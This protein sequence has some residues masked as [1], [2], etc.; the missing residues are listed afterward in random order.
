[1]TITQTDTTRAG[2]TVVTPEDL[3]RE[4][5]AVPLY[6]GITAYPVAWT[7]PVNGERL[8]REAF[9]R[10]EPGAGYPEQDVH[11]DSSETVL[12]LLG[13]LEDENGSYTPG[14]RI[15]GARGSFHTPRS[16]TGCL[17]YV[18]FPDR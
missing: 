18:T 7:D 9:V 3:E 10:F 14:T 1:M 17:L 16:S 4:Y 8:P 12:V 2:F 6:E 15:E 13:L 11:A 5:P